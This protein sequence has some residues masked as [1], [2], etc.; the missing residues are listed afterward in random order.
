MCGAAVRSDAPNCDHCGAK[1]ATVACPSCFAM[2]FEGSHFCPQCGAR[3]DRSPGG[4]SNY[5]CPR[6]EIRLT[7]ISIGKANLNEC[8]NC[9]GLW[10]DRF[11]FEQICTDREEQGALLGAA[12]ELPPV[13]GKEIVRYIKCPEC[14]ELMARVNFAGHSGVVIDVCRDH[15]TWF[16]AKE[17]QRII[18]FIRDGGMEREKERQIEELDK[19]RRQLKADEAFAKMNRADPPT[20]YN[21]PSH[22]DLS[23]II[24]TVSDIVRFFRP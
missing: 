11:S 14:Q 22:I 12:V 7:A 21:T 16:D 13:E 17:L 4:A 24:D 10:I 18:K 19:M 5:D 15:G 8:S 9:D 3:L 20:Y 23:D 1:L 2:V 6:C